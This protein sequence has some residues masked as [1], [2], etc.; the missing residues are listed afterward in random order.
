MATRV[1]A[2]LGAEVLKL[3]GPTRPDPLR[4]S[5]RS[6]LRLRY[7]DLD[8]GI[9]PQNRN[10]WFNTQN[11]D[12]KSIV[13]DLKSAEGRALLER[14]VPLCD[15]VLANYRPG[16]LARLGLGYSDLRSMRPDIIL[17]EMPGYPSGSSQVD[18]PAYGAQFDAA[19]GS[20]WL[21]GDDVEPLLTG[22]ALGDAVAGLLAASA[23]VSALARRSRTGQGNHL[24]VPQSTAML[25]LMG[26]YFAAASVGREVREPLNG[27]YGSSPHGVY[28]T[29]EGHWLALA[30]ETD[31]QWH[32]FAERYV[33]SVDPAAGQR[34][35]AREARLAHANDVDALVR[36]WASTVEDLHTVVKD[37][38][39]SGLP[40]APVSDAAAICADAQLAQSEFFRPLHHASAGTHR[41]P[42]L[43]IRIGGRRVAPRSAAPCFG[44]H[45]ETLLRNLL[46]LSEVEVADLAARGIV[47]T[48]L[49]GSTIQSERK[50]VENS[51]E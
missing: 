19:S 43:P 48:G 1:L 33:A 29:G 2:G 28:P 13:I 15:V 17:I 51:D 36:Q 10:A 47:A 5:G 16:V 14:I 8:Y 35:A 9:D 18:A 37:L 31:E 34:Y 26:E 23:A 32:I 41:Y 21:T 3:E 39:A 50:G 44:A 7:P 11:T 30:I 27:R 49:P 24:E 40:A 6:D 12:K 46:G 4:G 25:P 20:A 22:F 38:Q 45:T 42:G